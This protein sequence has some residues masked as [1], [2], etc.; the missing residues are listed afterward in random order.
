MLSY[1]T[2]NNY[3]KVLMPRHTLSSKGPRKPKRKRKSGN[4]SS[5]LAV[6]LILAGFTVAVVVVIALVAIFGGRANAGS[7]TPGDRDVLRSGSETPVVSDPESR[8][9]GSRAVM[10][11][12]EKAQGDTPE[13]A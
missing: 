9:E 13:V 12:I 11:G 2:R 10:S 4:A 7:L 5:D 1:E 3:E 8:Y 6:V